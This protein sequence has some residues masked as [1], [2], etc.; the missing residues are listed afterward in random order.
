[1]VMVSPELLRRYQF[2][3]LLSDQQL[4]NLAMVSEE[5]QY[6]DKEVILE[7]GKPADALYFLM[8]GGIDL[9]YTVNE[10][11][12]AEDRMEVFVGEIN[13]GEP[14]GISALIEPHRLTSTARSNGVSRVVR[15]SKEG[16]L[17]LFEEDQG[18]EVLF[19]RRIAKAAIDRLNSSRIQLAAAWA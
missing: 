14:F 7:E 18:F 13:P 2:F 1:M 5:V 3:S 4:R 9:Y 19:L 10:A 11:Y 12:H 17:S 6:V 8:E 15:M 16:L